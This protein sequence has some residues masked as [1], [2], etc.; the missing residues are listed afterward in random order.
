MTGL[1]DKKR[2]KF[3]RVPKRIEKSQIN[4]TEIWSRL[5]NPKGSRVFPLEIRNASIALRIV[6][7]FEVMSSRGTSSTLSIECAGRVKCLK[8][9][10]VDQ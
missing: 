9:R 3:K 8:R 5:F 1:V 2:V 4:R 6:S 10:L 7:L